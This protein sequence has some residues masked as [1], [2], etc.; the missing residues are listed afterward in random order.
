MSLEIVRF[1]GLEPGL[2]LIVLG[3]VHGNETCGAEAITGLIEDCRAGRL[4]VKRGQVTFVPVANRKAYDQG[5]R[6]GDRNLNRDLREYVM[7]QCHEDRVAN[8]LCPLL[9]EH[10]VLLDVHSFSGEGEPFVFVGPPDNAGEVEPFRHAAAEGAF[11]AMLGPS[12]LMHGFMA[13]QARAQAA[14]VR[15]GLPGSS[16]TKGV[17]TTEYMRRN[18]GYGVTIECGQH[19]DPNA[20]KVARQAILNALA[21]LQLVD[22]PPPPRTANRAIEVVEVTYALSAEDKFVRAWKTRDPVR[23]AEPIAR[24]ADGTVLS[25][26][27]DGFIVFPSSNIQ[28]MSELYYFGIPSTRFA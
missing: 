7:P 22:A 6:E 10:H 28:P 25:A 3:A 14:L 21:H 11:A 5:T 9:R 17:G 18:G 8:V 23:K 13:A 1:A 26:P 2:K 4:Q 27:S 19:R 20:P 15:Q 12:L 16:L 24:R